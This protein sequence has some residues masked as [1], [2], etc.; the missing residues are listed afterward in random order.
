[1][2]VQKGREVTP[3][4]K[5]EMVDCLQGSDILSEGSLKFR[6]GSL[7]NRGGIWLPFDTHTRSAHSRKGASSVLVSCRWPLASRL[8]KS[9]I[10]SHGNI[11]K[12]MLKDL[13]L[14]RI[15]WQ[16]IKLEILK[17]ESAPHCIHI[18]RSTSTDFSDSQDHLNHQDFFLIH[19]T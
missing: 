12:W 9:S 6:I 10:S 17:T 7:R 16:L 13:P 18:W 19:R 15:S 5:K 1:M 3:R 2:I 8:S 11:P 4:R 14:F